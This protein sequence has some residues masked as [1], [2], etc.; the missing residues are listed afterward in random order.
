MIAA[1]L[2]F[3]GFDVLML[4]HLPTARTNFAGIRAGPSTVHPAKPRSIDGV[5]VRPCLPGVVDICIHIGQR[6]DDVAVG[7]DVCV[8][9]FGKPALTPNGHDR[10]G[11]RAKRHL[12]Q[13]VARMAIWAWDGIQRGIGLGDALLEQL[14]VF[15]Q[16]Q[17]VDGDGIGQK[18]TA[19]YGQQRKQIG[20]TDVLV[21]VRV[22]VVGVVD[23]LG[24]GACGE[25]KDRGQ[26]ECQCRDSDSRPTIKKS[27]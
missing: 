11:R 20:R 23:G 27:R 19:K 21:G 6:G 8:Q 9:V 10:V 2:C 26:E 25:R 22:R 14:Q 18:L 1:N 12:R 24:G 13:A 15:L 5:V 7:E 17:A 3:E 4:R 16:R